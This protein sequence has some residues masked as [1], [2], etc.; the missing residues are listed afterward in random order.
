MA[1]FFNENLIMKRWN[2]IQQSVVGCSVVLVSCCV[3]LTYILI[4]RMENPWC[5][6]CL[7]S[8]FLSINIGA[9]VWSG[10][11]RRELQEALFPSMGLASTVIMSMSFWLSWVDTSSAEVDIPFQTDNITT[12]SSQEGITL[13]KK[14]KENGSK[15]YGAF[16]CSHCFDQKQLFGEPAIQDLPY[17]ECY[18]EGYRKGVSM[19]DEC[20]QANLRGFPTWVINGK[21]IEGEQT[22]DQL[23]AALDGNV[24]D[25]VE[26][27]GN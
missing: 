13:A 21:E 6:W 10:L 16:W 19:N 14:L 26:Q 1:G 24:D 22:F 7:L 5:L 3:V 18:P 23:S 12:Q 25:N 15:M 9:T 4:T 8:V 17:V 20:L 11:D 27:Q 2:L